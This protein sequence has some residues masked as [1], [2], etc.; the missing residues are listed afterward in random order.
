MVFFS[1]KDPKAEEKWN[2][3]RSENQ[4]VSSAPK[5]KPLPKSGAFGF[6]LIKPGSLGVSDAAIGQGHL[7]FLEIQDPVPW[8]ALGS[9]DNHRAS[10]PIDHAKK[11]GIIPEDNSV[12][13]AGPIRGSRCA[14]LLAT[15][16]KFC[17][18][19]VIDIHA[20]GQLF[21]GAQ[22]IRMIPTTC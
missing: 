5:E 1:T 18:I 7:W 8:S 13:P 3:G 4:Q 20:S 22:R 14:F 10:G 15:L 2:W 17:K 11:N 16:I 12:A 19:D 6:G 21:F 9:L